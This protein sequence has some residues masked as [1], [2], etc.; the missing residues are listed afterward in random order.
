MLQKFKL[1]AIISCVMFFSTG[2]I[3]LNPSAVFATSPQSIVL[4]YNS[5]TQTLSATITHK[6]LMPSFHYV[7]YVEILKNGKSVS[8]NT[9][10]NQ[11]DET[12]FSYTYKIP[13]FEGDVFEVTGTCSLWGSKT[14]SYTVG[15]P[16]AR[17]ESARTK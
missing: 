17:P 12:T 11:P 6:S 8:S 14:V 5:N 4:D 2:I 15:K 7:Q 3:C 1:T 16:V 13:A 10:A 9:Y